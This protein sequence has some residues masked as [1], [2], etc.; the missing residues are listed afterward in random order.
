MDRRIRRVVEWLEGDWRRPLRL[1]D[2][3]GRVGLG[4]SR[5]E[6]LFKTHTKLS[7]RE[8]VREKRLLEAAQLLA[9]T[10][11]RVSQIGYAVGFRDMSN[12]DHA[13]KRRFGMSPREYRDGRTR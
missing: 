1:A 6:H 9:S 7:I 3:A 12:F 5:L 11:E 13:F 8:F 4:V 10:D 2:L